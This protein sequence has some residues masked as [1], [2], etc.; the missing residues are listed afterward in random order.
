MELVG[1]DLP[2][3]EVWAVGR[4]PWVVAVVRSRKHERNVRM[5]LK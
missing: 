3:D 2:G 5:A 4:R 1:G